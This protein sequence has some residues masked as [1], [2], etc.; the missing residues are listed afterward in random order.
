MTG[1]VE[2]LA[3]GLYLVATPIGS[4]RD[5]TLRALDILASADVLAAE[6]TRT[7]RHLLT[8]HGVALNGRPVVAYHDHNGPAVRPRLL[9][10]IRMGGSLAYASDAGT[11]GIAD[12]GHTLVREAHAEGLMVTAAPGPSAAITALSISGLPT[13]RFHFAGFAPAASG[14]RKRFLSDLAPVSATLI[15]YE[16]PKRLDRFLADAVE[17]FGPDRQVVIARELTKKFEELRKGS[18]GD[19]ARLLADMPRKGEI[20]ILIDRAGETRDAGDLDA[21]LRDALAAGSIKDAARDVAEALGLP[22][23]E[24]YQRALALAKSR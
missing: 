5:I 22:R 2:T 8:L 4:A 7:L 13:D 3:A 9:D 1:R 24:V 10:G 23:R 11:P 16:S 21:A 19:M 17:V 15:L 20:V 6:D 12:P 14:A 18:L